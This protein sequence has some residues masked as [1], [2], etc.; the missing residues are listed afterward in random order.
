MRSPNENAG[1]GLVGIMTVST[2]ANAVFATLPRPAIDA[3]RDEF[4]FYDWDEAANEVRW[5][6]AFDT[7]EDAI[8]AFVD[9]IGVALRAV[10]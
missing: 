1:T 5:M 3:L 7:T 4:H 9:A 2:D 8:D 10:R 6:T